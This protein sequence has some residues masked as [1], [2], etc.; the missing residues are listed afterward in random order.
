MQQLKHLIEK[1]AFG[2]CTF[3]GQYLGIAT[4]KIRLYFIYIS[5]LTMGS[6]I[7]IYLFFAFW[8]NFKKHMRRRY[9]PVVD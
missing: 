7:V 1:S 4:S 2:V 8:L 9:N 6:P 3:W 5:M